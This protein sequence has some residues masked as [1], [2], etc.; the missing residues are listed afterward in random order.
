[1][2]CEGREKKSVG[3]A[4]RAGRVSLTQSQVNAD[5]MQSALTT[6]LVSQSVCLTVSIQLTMA[7]PCHMSVT[8]GS[9]KDSS[10]CIYVFLNGLLLLASSGC[11]E[12]CSMLCYWYSVL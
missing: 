9:S 8:G 5:D 10:L 6:A 2:V 12:Y 11:T 3:T 7:A 4:Q 1:M